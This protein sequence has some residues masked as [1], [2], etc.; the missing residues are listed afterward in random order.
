[1]TERT[2]QPA[3][4]LP[5][6]LLFIGLA[7]AAFAIDR[8]A[9]VLVVDQL[10]VGARRDLLGGVLELRH[11]H[12]RGIAFG[13]FSGAGS[14]VV[15]GSLLVG[16][17]LFIFLLR[18][19][20]SDHATIAGGGLITGGAIGNL[21]DRITQGYVTDFLHLPKWPT[22]NVADV[23]ICVGVALVILMQLVQGRREALAE[24]ADHAERAETTAHAHP[25]TLEPDGTANS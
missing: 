10:A 16:V 7:V 11:I 22:F 21:V 5:G 3:A 24:R 19:E 2:A 20:P 15:F 6:R 8:V 14:L 17:L 12:N 23:A 1:V 25:A 13:L 4:R 9:K 18:V